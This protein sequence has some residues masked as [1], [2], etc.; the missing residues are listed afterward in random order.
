MVTRIFCITVWVF[1]S[2][3]PLIFSFQPGTGSSCQET[4][5]F[6]NRWFFQ[7]EGDKQVISS[8]DLGIVKLDLILETDDLNDSESK[9]F[10]NNAFLLEVNGRKINYTALGGGHSNLGGKYRMMKTIAFRPGSEAGKKRIRAVMDKS[11][12]EI[13]L[14]YQPKGQ[15]VFCDIFDRLAVFGQ[16]EFE[17]RWFGYYL[18]RNSIIL[19]LNGKPAPLEFQ[20]SAFDPELLRGKII[21]NFL[22][23]KNV[24]GFHA[25]D[26]SGK[27]LDVQKIVFYYPSNKI[28]TGDRFLLRLGPLGGKSGPFYRARVLGGA[29]SVLSPGPH[30]SCPAREEILIRIAECGLK[31][32]REKPVVS[33]FETVKPGKSIIIIEKKRH[34]K[35]RE[36]RLQNKIYVTIE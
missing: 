7:I 10:K 6:Q 35:E 1:I 21:N 4:G 30:H 12:A 13:V 22:P 15:I 11:Y 18:D 5:E 19:N 20:E 16:Q 28:R 8:H 9:T 26:L 34:F 17:V 24:I 32:E 25:E 36:W 3:L 2:S 23:D 29:L 33:E 14:D 31:A 27:M